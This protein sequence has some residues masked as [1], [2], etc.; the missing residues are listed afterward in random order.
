M[1]SCLIFPSG[2]FPFFS[3][4]F[5]KKKRHRKVGGGNTAVITILPPFLLSNEHNRLFFR[6]I[7]VQLLADFL[8]FFISIHFL[9]ARV[10]RFWSDTTLSIVFF[11]LKM[12]DKIRI[13]F[14]NFTVIRGECNQYVNSDVPRSWWHRS[15]WHRML[16]KRSGR[17]L[18]HLQ[19]K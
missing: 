14:L 7:I 1:N 4:C 8:L 9:D 13:F 3:D 18:K 12:I 5:M 11:Y 6:S 19:E 16:E 15:D 17:K 10:F 2:Y